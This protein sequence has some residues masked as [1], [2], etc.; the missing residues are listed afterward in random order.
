MTNLNYKRKPY[1][2]L[3]PLKYIPREEIE[4]DDNGILNV[5]NGYVPSDYEKAFAVSSAPIIGGILEQG[6]EVYGD[7]TYLPKINGKTGWR[8]LLIKKTK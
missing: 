3:M 6:F 4:I 8:R 5:N 1:K 2:K 7:E